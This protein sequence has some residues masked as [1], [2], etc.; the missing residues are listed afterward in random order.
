MRKGFQKWVFVVGV[1][2]GG[3]LG[4]LHPAQAEA[5]AEACQNQCDDEGCSCFYRCFQ[6]GPHCICE[7]FPTCM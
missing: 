5:G 1:V 6:L 2:A 7:E 4:V 3:A